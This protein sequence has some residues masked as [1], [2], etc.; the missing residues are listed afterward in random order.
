MATKSLND[1]MLEYFSTAN[2]SGGGGAISS[3]QLPETLGQKTEAGSLSIEI[4]SDSDLLTILNTINT[5]LQEIKTADAAA[6]MAAG[7]PFVNLDVDE[8]EDAIKATP[9]TLLA[10]VAYNMTA[11]PRWLKLFDATVA[12]T[13]V[14]TTV[15]VFVTLVPAGTTDKTGVVIPLGPTGIGFANAITIAATTGFANT[16][17]GPPG[18]NDVIVSGV[19]L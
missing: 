9:G 3:E 18:N 2:A 8:T 17:V 15:P 4:A 6:T 10:I 1:E 13:T 14:G 19:Y 5:S 11:S 16:D 7:T 12:N